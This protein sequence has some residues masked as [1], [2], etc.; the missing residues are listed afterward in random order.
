MRG[1]Q[2]TLM[3]QLNE[4]DMVK[5]ELDRLGE[6]D[7]VYKMVGP[8]LIKHELSEAK[9]TVEKRLEF[10]TSDLGKVEAT[11]GQKEQ[12]AQEIAAGIQKK[13]QE[14]QRT[15]KEEAERIAKEASV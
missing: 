2:Q 7:V 9:T 6:N 5:T 3:Q 8:V 14:M 10:I 11:A 1:N 15:A 4:N 12:E 13:Q